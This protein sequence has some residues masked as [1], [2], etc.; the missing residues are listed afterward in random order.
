MI[1]GRTEWALA[2]LAAFCVL[3]VFFFPALQGPYPAVHG[4]VTALLSLRAAARLRL[5]AM[6]N[7]LRLIAAPVAR[8]AAIM[9]ALLRSE[10]VVLHSE[11]E[12]SSA[13]LGSI[14]RC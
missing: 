10:F 11:M 1:S 7:S 9:P 6:R 8:I 2:V 14:L 13:A 12:S 5:D 3:V 4:P